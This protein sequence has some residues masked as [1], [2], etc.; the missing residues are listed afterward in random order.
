MSADQPQQVP[1]HCLSAPP[2]L[3]PF[4]QDQ[5]TTPSGKDTSSP[6]PQIVS[7]RHKTWMISQGDLC[8]PVTL[9]KGFSDN[10]YLTSA[11]VWL[12]KSECFHHVVSFLSSRSC[13]PVWTPC[14]VL[15]LQLPLR[16]PPHRLIIKYDA[17]NVCCVIVRN[18]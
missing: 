18:E 17:L 2:S 4:F 6:S 8:Q 10:K 13:V 1:S 3:Q 14:S 11:H 7:N 12:W 9:S 15:C 5:E 16:P